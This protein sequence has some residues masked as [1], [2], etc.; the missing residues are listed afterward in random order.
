MSKEKRDL[1][2]GRKVFI[3][4]RVSTDEQK[5]TL[6]TQTTAVKKALKELGYTGK[7][8]VFEEQASGTNIDR[9][10]L[11]KMIEAAKASKKPAVIVVRDIQ[12]FARDPYDLG[13]LYNP[14]KVREIPI[15]SINEPIITGTKKVPQPAADLLAPILV[16][17]GGSEVSTRKKQTLQGVAESRKKGIFSGTPLSLYPNEKIEPRRFQLTLLEAGI[18]QSEGA[19]RLGKSTGYWR[20]NRDTMRKYEELGVLDD[21]LDT[22]DLIRAMEQEKGEGKGPRAGIKM[23]TVRRMTSGYLNDP[24]AGFPKPTQEMLDEY[25][26]NFNKYRPKRKK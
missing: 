14:L 20:D 15:M 9:T 26:S 22:I 1:L 3:Y 16:A 7:P 13:E 8:E 5:G 21:W 6:P 2:K 12:R 4:S 24:T 17:A 18:G 10:E 19:R 11:T 25:Y 23:K